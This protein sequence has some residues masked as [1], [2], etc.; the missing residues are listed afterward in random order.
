MTPQ[1]K[2]A[3]RA[4]AL[5]C[6]TAGLL[7]S[8]GILDP[9]LR[10]ATLP[11]KVVM[12]GQF[13][14]PTVAALPDPCK[15]VGQVV[16]LSTTSRWYRCSQLSP[17]IWNLM[18][19][20]GTGTGDVQGPGSSATN[21][22]VLY[23]DATGK[24]LKTDASTGIPHLTAG[25][26][27]T[28]PVVSTDMNL[29]G[30][31]R[32]TG[33]FAP[34]SYATANLPDPCNVNDVAMDSTT[35]ELKRCSTSSPA[36]WTPVPYRQQTLEVCKSGCPYNEPFDAMNA[37]LDSSP[38]KP[39]NIY[40][41][42]GLYT[43]TVNMKDNTTITCEDRETTAIYGDVGSISIAVASGVDEWKVQGCTLLNN[44]PIGMGADLASPTHGYVDDCQLNAPVGN[45]W[46]V[47]AGIDC[48]YS[49]SSN[50]G[51]IITITNSTLVITGVGSDCL[52]LG[53]G[54]DYTLRNVIVTGPGTTYGF[55]RF[56]T[57]TGF[58]LHI[59][60]LTHVGSTS[61]DIIDYFYGTAGS[62]T[63]STTGPIIDVRNVLW[64]F[65]TSNT[66]ARTN[67][68]W[69]FASSNPVSTR[70]SIRIQNFACQIAATS[71][72]ANQTI[73]AYDIGG[74][75]DFANYQ[76]ELLDSSN[77]LSGGVSTP[78]DINVAADTAGFDFNIATVVH[79]GVYTGAGIS[80]IT[81][82]NLAN[83]KF[84]ALGTGP[85][86]ATAGLL[87][88]GTPGA[89][90]IVGTCTAGDEQR[91]TG[92]ATVEY[93]VCHTTNVWGCWKMTDGT[94]TANGPFD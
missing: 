53:E 48:I 28:G 46:G 69:N 89:D 23:A 90:L 66:V 16:V 38:T 26:I 61:A 70:A 4:A 6:V 44:K 77:I 52:M 42:S 56:V 73:V 37:I 79:S 35:G 24:V 10:A 31:F 33:P 78:T 43:K 57:E 74:D 40:V 30:A 18:N 29:S 60:G 55:I 45:K 80:K 15:Y 64:D 20:T 63:S 71:A 65:T 93:C 3:A 87:S 49:A 11:G 81:Q 19:P 39:Y 54:D 41:H 58:K 25:V 59:D 7:L 36:A 76:I 8:F 1:L 84:G 5:V 82:G 86:R 94:F 91:D 50:P 17:A 72:S 92:G 32:H 12:T 14:P 21:G 62:L 75:S 67:K 51:H 88:S 22:L 34:P 27:S 85:V 83:A 2:E 68:C 13:L 9:G 47:S